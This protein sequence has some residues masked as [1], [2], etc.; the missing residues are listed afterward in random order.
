MPE[1][2]KAILAGLQ[3]YMATKGVGGGPTQQTPPLFQTNKKAF[4]DSTLQANK[5]LDWVQRLYEKNAPTFQVPGEPDRSTHFMGDDG[6]GYVFPTVV[7]QNG[8]LTYLGD[9]AEDYAR[10]TKTG[11]QFPKEQGDWFAN[12]G[13]KIGSGVNN[14]ISPQGVPFNNP[15]YVIPQ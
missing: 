12:N 9:K 14:S 3:Q 7:R 10:E 15:H 13:Y 8:K 5:H 11:I 6:N 1:A 4:V 2:N